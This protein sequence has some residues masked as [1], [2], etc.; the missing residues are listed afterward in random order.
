MK[1]KAIRFAAFLSAALTTAAEIL[2]GADLALC[3]V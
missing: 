1:T 2:T 3:D